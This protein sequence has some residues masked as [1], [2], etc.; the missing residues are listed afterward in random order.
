MLNLGV[1]HKQHLV[2]LTKQSTQV[3]QDFCKLALDYLQKG[4]NLKL[5]SAAAQKLQV[6]PQVIRNSVEGLVQ[7]LFECCKSKLEKDSFQE[8]ILG[9]GFSEE[10]ESLLSKLYTVKK[11]ELTEALSKFGLKL[12]QYHDMDWRFEVQIASRSLL[13]QVVPLVTLDFS[14]KNTSNSDQVEHVLLQTDPNNLLHLAQEL[15]MAVREGRTITEYISQAMCVCPQEMEHPLV[16]AGM[17]ATGEFDTSSGSASSTTTMVTTAAVQVASTIGPH[18]ARQV[19][20]AFGNLTVVDKVPPEMLHLVGPHWY[21]FP[22]LWPIWHKLLGVVMIFIGILGWCGNGMVVYIFLVT[23]SLRTPSNLL[24]INLAFSDFVMMIIMSPPMVVNCW[25]ETWVLGPLMCDIYAL[26]GSLCGGASIW[27]MTAIAYDRYNV[28]VKGMSGTPLTI[29]RALV[30]IVLI[31]THGLIWAMLPLFGWN[32]YVPEGNMT[33]CGTDYVSDDWLGKS[34]I[35]VYSI[36]VYYTPL[37]SII[38]CYW[39]IVSAVAAHERGMREQAKKM[40]VAS[41]RSGDQ[42][43]ESAEVKLAKVAITTISLWFLAWTPYLVTNYMGIF[44]KQHVT[45]LF[46]IWASL[47]A[48]TNACYNPIVY[49]FSHPKYRAGLKVKC[50]CLVFGDTEDKPKSAAAAPAADAASTHSKA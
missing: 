48:K 7:L 41:L 13:R 6:E 24:V 10:Q 44:A 25:F 14:L 21:Q 32:R 19:M 31:W 9:L 28:I 40:N 22:P 15:E 8:A 5:Y 34:Y 39:H 47:F 17:N 49:A 12:P 36:F 42:S 50:P 3:L 30:Q 16:A 33:S 18:F 23:P 26:I 1:D 29:P 20:R 27:T 4:P 11:Q 45:P 46:T 38:L 43:G 35:L 2:F 37:F